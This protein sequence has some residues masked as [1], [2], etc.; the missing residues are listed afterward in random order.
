MVRD[1][2]GVGGV[3]SPEKR[4]ANMNGS[5]LLE[6]REVAAGCQIS[7]K[8]YISLECPLRI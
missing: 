2:M 8:Y 4:I 5:T 6:L 3:K 7:R 1:T